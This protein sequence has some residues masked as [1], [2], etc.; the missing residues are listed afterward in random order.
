MGKIGKYFFNFC[1]DESIIENKEANRAMLTKYMLCRTQKMFK[2]K[3]LPSTIPQ[4]ML[5]LYLQTHGHCCVASVNSELYALW[6]NLGGEPNAYYIPTRYVVA[7]PYLKF[8]KDLKVDEECVVGKN[9]SMYMGLLP[10]Y[11][12]YAS[13]I[14]ENELSI[15]LA[16]INSRIISLISASDDRTKESAI[17]FLKNI[18][19][20]KLGVIAET[21][22]LEGLK[23]QPYANSASINA[24][25]EL[26]EHEQYLKASWFNDLGLQSNFN[27]KREAINSAESALNEDAL[28]PLIDDMLACRQEFADNINNMFGTDISVSL[29]SSWEDNQA[30]LDA[31]MEMLE[32][33]VEQM[34]NPE[35]EAEETED[36][37]E[38]ETEPSDTKLEE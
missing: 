34:Q 13:Q 10:L 26:I 33:E 11:S 22:F 31:N 12:K 4:R 20:G 25:K 21:P 6:G 35:P 9:D 23:S 8:S 29:D 24:L 28:F 7:N 27:M 19:S 38:N 37:R 32:A 17:E 15:N 3:N 18:R 14:A 1:N 2:W 16:M 5:E 30:E 36:G